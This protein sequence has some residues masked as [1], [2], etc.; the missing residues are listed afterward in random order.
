MLIVQHGL[1]VCT[2]EK[3]GGYVRVGSS[4]AAG[5]L[6][7]LLPPNLLLW[8][9]QVPDYNTCLQVGMTRGGERLFSSSITR[10]DIDNYLCHSCEPNCEFIIGDDLACGLVALRDIE[11]GESINFDYDTTEDDLT[12]DRGGFECHCGAP[13]CR[14]WI[15]GKL[16][17]PPPGG[18]PP[19]IMPGNGLPYLAPER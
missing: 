13:A 18:P 6:V 14:K 15:L 2:N 4:I 5:E 3:V 11:A 8:D 9:S 19:G 10:A 1:K 16:H 7:M 17:S 12:G